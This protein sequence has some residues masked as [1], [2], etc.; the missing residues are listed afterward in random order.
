MLA[1]SSHT[2][3][4]RRV[5][6]SLRPI[7]NS[8]VGPQNPQ[9]LPDLFPDHQCPAG[10]PRRELS[11]IHSFIL[12]TFFWVPTLPTGLIHTAKVKVALPWTS[13]SKAR[14]LG[15][16]ERTQME[17]DVF[18]WAGAQG[19]GQPRGGKERQG[20]GILRHH[21]QRCIIMSRSDCS[22]C[23][24][25]CAKCIPFN[26]QPSKEGALPAPMD[27]ESC[28]DFPKVSRLSPSAGTDTKGQAVV[29]L[30]VVLCRS[31][32]PKLCN[33]DFIYFVGTGGHQQLL[34]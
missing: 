17:L 26:H 16:W 31:P 8:Q 10:G 3:N 34:S 23:S 21:H 33:P 2:R 27:P 5:C 1:S 15:G 25:H 29:L 4:P 19:V 6:L 7:G 20:P 13:P 22:L 14:E 24:Q 28:A 30:L 11:F 12:S 32:S 18:P 9:T